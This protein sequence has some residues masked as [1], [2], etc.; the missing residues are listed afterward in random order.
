M[1]ARLAERSGRPQSPPDVSAEADPAVASGTVA[2]AST[3]RDTPERLVLRVRKGMAPGACLALAGELVV[4]RDAS[5]ALVLADPRVSRRHVA[6]AASSS[7][8][9]FRDLG[10]SNGTLLN[11][12]RVASGALDCG[13]VMTLGDTELVIEADPRGIAF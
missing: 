1:L 11:G 9:H 6:I 7:T 8:P 13:D 10:S 3:L 5:C 12:R 4:G 2:I